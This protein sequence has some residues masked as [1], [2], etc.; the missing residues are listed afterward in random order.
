MFLFGLISILQWKLEFVFLWPAP[1]ACIYLDPFSTRSVHWWQR[2][3][4]WEDLGMLL[5]AY[6]VFAVHFTKLLEVRR[7][8]SAFDGKG[9]SYSQRM[10]PSSIVQIAS[11]E[12]LPF[13]KSQAPHQPATT[14][15]RLVALQGQWTNECF[16]AR[17]DLLCSVR[18]W[19]VW[20]PHILYCSFPKITC[21]ETSHKSQPGE[22]S[23]WGQRGKMVLQVVHMTGCR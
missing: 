21:N 23:G 1:S 4:D 18:L 12:W 8:F 16:L 7:T 5:C 2:L 9:C 17:C 19:F 22:G 14:L 10:V 6:E 15:V 3:M 20:Y 11:Y 13:T